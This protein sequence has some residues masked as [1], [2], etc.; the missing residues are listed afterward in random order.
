MSNIESHSLL[1]WVYF[2]TDT[3]N[4]YL[5]PNAVA[6][7][8]RH[9]LQEANNKFINS[10]KENAGMCFLNA[11]VSPRMDFV[12][13]KHKQNACLFHDYLWANSHAIGE[14]ADV[15]ISHVYTSGIVSSI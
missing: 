14:G 15:N 2:S 10:D 4:C 9:L 6:E 3:T 8:Y 1:V 13:D 12:E 7:Q 11:A 5:I